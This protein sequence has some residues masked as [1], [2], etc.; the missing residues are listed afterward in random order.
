MRHSFFFSYIYSV[1]SIGLGISY[2]VGMLH[3]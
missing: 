1:C 3:A 2:N